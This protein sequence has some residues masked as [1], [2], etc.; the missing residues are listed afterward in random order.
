MLMRNEHINN[1][2]NEVSTS[3][4][5]SSV[6]KLIALFKN[7]DNVSCLYLIHKYNSGF[8]HFR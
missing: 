8:V 3:T 5:G 6:D 1:I 4:G 2:V 7:T